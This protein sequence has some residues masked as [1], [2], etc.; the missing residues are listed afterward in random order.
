MTKM[1]YFHP[2]NGSVLHA[3]KI[4]ANSKGSW[5]STNPGRS[6]RAKNLIPKNQEVLAIWITLIKWHTREVLTYKIKILKGSTKHSM[7]PSRP[8]GRWIQPEHPTSSATTVR[9][10]ENPVSRITTLGRWLP[11]ERRGLWI[12]ASS[13]E[14]RKNRWQS[15]VSRNKTNR[16]R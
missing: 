10:S 4:W 9:K 7:T 2:R 8:P 6:S 5:D 1:L 16:L 14:F 15:K 11:R 12:R 13:S 3:L